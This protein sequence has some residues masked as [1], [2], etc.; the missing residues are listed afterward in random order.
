MSKATDDRALKARRT[1]LS[2][3]LHGFA[4]TIIEM[5][6]EAVT[7][8]E[9]RVYI[10]CV[11]EILGLAHWYGPHRLPP[12][13][14]RDEWTRIIEMT[15]E[16]CRESDFYTILAMTRLTVDEMAKAARLDPVNVKRGLK[17]LFKP[18]RTV[19]CGRPRSDLKYGDWRV[20]CKRVLVDK[21]VERNYL[22]SDFAETLLGIFQI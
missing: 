17:Q 7:T 21:L 5:L 9:R 19:A 3:T 18:G 15:P 8:H 4:N 22:E 10:D 11:L 16:E 6:P 13:K 14:K 1:H 12:N 20:L 2:E